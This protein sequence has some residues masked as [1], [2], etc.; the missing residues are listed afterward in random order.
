MYVTNSPAIMV[1]MSAK[2][3]RALCLSLRFR[4]WFQNEEQ[5]LQRPLGS[6]K[7]NPLSIIKAFMYSHYICFFSAMLGNRLI[8]NCE[9]NII[10]VCKQ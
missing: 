8:E 2:D 9:N 10:V 5:T 7:W 1:V 3:H 4:N 6:E